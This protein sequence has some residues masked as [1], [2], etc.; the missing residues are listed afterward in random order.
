MSLIEID[1]NPDH[2]KLRQFSLIWL[3]GFGIVGLFLAWRLG[4]FGGAGSW[5]TPLL[6]WSLAAAVGLLGLL[7]PRA[8]KPVYK[9]WMAVTFPI[10]WLLS[11]IFLAVIYY[12]A[13]TSLG[14]IFRLIGRDPLAR[15]RTEKSDTYWIERSAKASAKRYFQ[16]F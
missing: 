16:Q 14:L 3:C 1:W 13:F 7:F 8:V 9:A 2:P 10:G 15:H 6:L 5:T 12:G 11:H 4:C